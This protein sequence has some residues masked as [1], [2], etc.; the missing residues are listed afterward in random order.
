[1]EA[2]ALR[3]KKLEVNSE[4]TNVIRSWKQKPKIF[5]CFYISGSLNQTILTNL[6]FN[7]SIGYGLNATI[8]W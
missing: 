7:R 5:Y 3:R 8:G 2:E 4:A 6:I 1:M